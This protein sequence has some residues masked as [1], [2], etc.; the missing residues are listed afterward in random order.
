VRVA[1]RG[2]RDGVRN[3]EVML[4]SWPHICNLYIGE[5]RTEQLGGS[6]WKQLRRWRAPDDDG[7]SKKPFL[8]PLLTGLRIFSAENRFTMGVLPCKLPLI[9]VIA[10][11]K[12][13]MNTQIGVADSKYVVLDDPTTRS[14]DTAHAHCQ[15]CR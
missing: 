12:V 4:E 10:P 7:F 9:V 3:L 15:C 8:S 1:G 2:H 14:R 5:H 13:T 6:L 11:W